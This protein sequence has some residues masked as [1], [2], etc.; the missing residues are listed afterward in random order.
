V[1][2]T[3]RKKVTEHI[4]IHII[5]STCKYYCFFCTFART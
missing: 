3:Y 2:A 5:T 4:H 1:N